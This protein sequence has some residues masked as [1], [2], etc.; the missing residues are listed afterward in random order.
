MDL[1]IFDWSGTLSDDRQV[2][3]QA[4]VL[5]ARR[6]GIEPILDFDEWLPQTRSGPQEFFKKRGTSASAEEI[7]NMYKLCLAE[8]LSTGAKPKIYPEV[9]EVISALRN[10][11]KKLVVISSHPSNNLI[12][13][14]R[15]YGIVD[16][17]DDIV[18]SVVNKA[19]AI[20]R[21]VTSWDIP[22]KMTVYI[23][24]MVSDIIAAKAAGVNSIALTRGYHPEEMLRAENPDLLWRNLLPLKDI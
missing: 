19:E 20:R 9:P 14:A 7:W 11:S 16:L 17:F 21:T 22:K 3:H 4:N 5:V 18:G 6:F 8:V 10:S 24:D 2:V 13:E 15:E 12:D 23:G 1:V